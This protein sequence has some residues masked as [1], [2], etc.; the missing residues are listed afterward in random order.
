M[1]ITEEFRRAPSPTPQYES[2]R[3]HLAALDQLEPDENASIRA[4]IE[5]ALLRLQ[6]RRL[7]QIS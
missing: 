7:A 5:G 1:S 6:A 4:L 2:L 3:L